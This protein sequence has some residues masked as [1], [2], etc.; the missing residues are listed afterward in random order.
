MTYS[1][2]PPP[3]PDLGSTDTPDISRADDAFGKFCFGGVCTALLED[4]ICWGCGAP[5]GVDCRAQTEPD[6][7][8]L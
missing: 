7:S 2:S 5:P 3:I 1:N 6:F 4:R 8:I